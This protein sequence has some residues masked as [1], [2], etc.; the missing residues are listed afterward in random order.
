MN[1]LIIKSSSIERL[2]ALFDSLRNENKN[3]GRRDVLT[4]RHWV[5]TIKQ[6]YDRCRPICYPFDGSFNKKDASTLLGN[7]LL[8]QYDRVIV[9]TSNLTGSGHHNV[10]K[11]AFLFG[12]KVYIYN[13]NGEIE[14]FPKSRL[15]RDAIKRTALSPV[16][17]S[18]TLLMWAVC[19]G[20]L[21]AHL[22]RRS[23]RLL[24]VSG[25]KG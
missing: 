17:L 2:D 4:H 14:L 16:V 25:S 15:R 5:D 7:E 23:L 3:S 11:T 18:G 9:L 1:T 21:L 10:L 19:G 12:E 24:T 6:S 20:L 8:S 13:V 22:V